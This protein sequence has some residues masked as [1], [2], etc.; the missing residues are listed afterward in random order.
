LRQRGK[1]G[2]D[3][4]HFGRED[5]ASRLSAGHDGRRPQKKP[6]RSAGAFVRAAIAIAG[7][8]G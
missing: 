3:A 8:Y 5:G 7:E 2:V 1:E 4:R 6:R